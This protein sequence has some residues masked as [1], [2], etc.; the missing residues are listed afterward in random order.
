M[1]L[2]SGSQMSESKLWSSPTALFSSRSAG[3]IRKTN[4]LGVRELMKTIRAGK[5][6]MLLGGLLI[7]TFAAGCFG[8]DPNYYSDRP[9]TYNTSYGVPATGEWFQGNSRIGRCHLYRTDLEPLEAN[10]KRCVG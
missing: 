7:A 8:G 1:L 9:Y 3:P 6:T 10:E 5:V 2:L 4:W